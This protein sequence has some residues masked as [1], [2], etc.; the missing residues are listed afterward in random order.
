MRKKR[1]VFEFLQCLS[2]M[3]NKNIAYDLNYDHCYI[4]VFDSRF[5]LNE[6]GLSELKQYLA[7]YDQM[8]RGDKNKISGDAASTDYNL[9]GALP[10]P[11]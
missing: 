6:G 10:K 2:S 9:V 3:N 1:L 5:E 4:K 11:W 7:V 8:S